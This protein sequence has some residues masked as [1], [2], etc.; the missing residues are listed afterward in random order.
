MR[1]GHLVAA[2][3]VGQG[4]RGQLVVRTSLGLACARVSSLRQGHNYYPRINS[5][6]SRLKSTATQKCEYTALCSFLPEFLA[7]F[8][9]GT[10]LANAHVTFDMNFAKQSRSLKL[11]ASR[12]RFLQLSVGG[13]AALFADGLTEPFMVQATR[14]DVI[15]PQLPPELEG[16]KVAQ[17]TDTHRGNLT[18]DAVIREAVRLAVAWEPDLVVLTGDYVRWDIVDAGPMAQMLTPLKPRLGMVGVLGNHDYLYPDAIARKLTEIAGV[19]MLRND[20]M[21]I[22][23]GFWIAGIEDT[24]EGKVDVARALRR[25]P[26][27][28]GFLF[29]THNPTGV[30]LVQQRACIALAG[31][32]HGG[33]F[34]CPGVTPH[35][36]PGMAG[37]AQIEGWGSYGK[38]RLY[39]S[40]GIGC[41]AYPLRINCPPELTLL[42]LRSS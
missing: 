33:Q 2:L 10:F 29:L 22:A 12:R 37:F 32:T 16:L 8:V 4:G 15:V 41:T 6:G 17:L 18:P 19:K 38:A 9:E 35:F 26:Q 3:A 30:S 20:A 25:I 40:R 23:P 28:A 1:P 5:V 24:L 27:E 34:R 39:I 21:E 42:T 36:P 31:H 13:A 14:S 11:A 7:F